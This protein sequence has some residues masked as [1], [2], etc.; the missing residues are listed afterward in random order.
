[1]ANHPDPS[2]FAARLLRQDE[3]VNEVKYQEYRMKLENALRAAEQRLKV[4]GWVVVVSCVISFTLMFV[5]GSKVI[6]DFDPWSR[7][8]NVASI[9][10][11]V[12]FLVATVLF[13]VSLASYYSRFRPGLADAKERLRDANILDLQRQI[14]ELHQLVEQNLRRDE[15]TSDRPKSG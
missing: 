8:A 2:D 12:V 4:T 6:G 5:G 11:G 10:V 15:S 9:V 3:P 14:R 13:W 7:N 1:M